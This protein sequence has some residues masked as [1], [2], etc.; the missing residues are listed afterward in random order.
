MNGGQVGGLVVAPHRLVSLTLLTATCLAP[1]AS[2]DVWA[3]VPVLE[4]PVPNLELPAKIFYSGT[5]C[6]ATPDQS[7]CT[8]CI[9]YG[10]TGDLPIYQVG[11]GDLGTGVGLPA[12]HGENGYGPYFGVWVNAGDRCERGLA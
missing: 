7:G 10:E 6:I 1:L 12:G 9:V 2:A 11:S 5:V 3:H 8:V 4:P